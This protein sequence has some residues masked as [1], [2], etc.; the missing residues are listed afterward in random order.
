MRE[1]ISIR[2]T[3]DTGQVSLENDEEILYW[4]NRFSVSE[5]RLRAAVEKVGSGVEAVAEALKG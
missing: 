4:S 5:D 3:I 1:T 2:E